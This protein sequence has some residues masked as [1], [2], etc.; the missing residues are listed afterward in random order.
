M[1]QRF[2]SLHIK[3][4]LH[5]PML[6]NLLFNTLSHPVAPRHALSRPIAPQTEKTKFCQS[7]LFLL[8][9][10]VYTKLGDFFPFYYIKIS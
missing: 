6:A 7:N 9:H 3:A 4:S 10:P 1:H 2:S 8:E 5:I